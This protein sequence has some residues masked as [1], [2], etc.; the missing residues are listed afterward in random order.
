[1]IFHLSVCRM[2][3]LPTIDSNFEEGKLLEVDKMRE[4]IILESIFVTSIL[5]K[6]K[7]HIIV[8]M[9]KIFVYESEMNKIINIK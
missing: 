9:V 2:K 5:S 7:N 1:M 6:R 8:L 3:I 4:F